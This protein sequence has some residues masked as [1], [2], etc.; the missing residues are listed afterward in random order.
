MKL[1]IQIPCLNEEQTLPETVRDLPR[2]VDGFDQVE[3]LVIDDG[4]TDRTIEVARELGVH[5]IEALPRNRGLAAAFSI[6]LEVAVSRGADVIV[7]TD[8]DN[9]YFGADVE[10][11]VRPIVEG[12][13]DMVIGD[14]RTGTIPHFSFMKKRL[15][16]LGSLA[17]RQLSGTSIPDATSG[18]RAFTRDTAL[19]LHIYSNFSYTLESIIQTS[20]R[21]LRV[22]SVPIRTNEQTRKSRLMRSTKHFV[23]RSAA[24][25]IRLSIF[26]RPFI[27]FSYLG[28]A[29]LLPGVL[30]GARFLYFLRIGS[31]GGHIQSLILATILLLMGSTTL[32]LGLI[33]NLLAA[34]RRLLEEQI[35]RSRSLALKQDHPPLEGPA[36]S[37]PR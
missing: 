3:Y 10:K 18:F 20:R 31:V 11:L 7:N 17:V 23:V 36:P 14:R 16:F 9:Q 35:Y 5:H 37:G 19:R 6:G 27:F 32:A 33:A 30:I 13:A 25:L 34:N 24:T 12:S 1:V 22:V 21:G 15:Q 28:G 29:L 8:G 4:S 2:T 26:Y